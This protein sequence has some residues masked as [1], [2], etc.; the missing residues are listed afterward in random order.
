M[1]STYVASPSFMLRL[2]YGCKTAPIESF[3]FEEL[4]APGSHP[5]YLWGSSAYLLLIS[6]SDK[7]NGVSG[8]PIHVYTD[9]GET[10]VTPCSE[11]YLSS[12]EVLNLEQKGCTVVQSVKGTNEVL[13]SQWVAFSN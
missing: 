1:Q 9:D 11:Y 3:K 13:I 7:V 10:Q 8:L 12:R 4:A 2:P 6:L 5:Y